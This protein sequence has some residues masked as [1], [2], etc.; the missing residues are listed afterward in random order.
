MATVARITGAVGRAFPSEGLSL[1]HS[2]GP[3]AFQEV[4]HL[5]FHIHPR[6]H[7]STVNRPL[8]RCQ[9]VMRL[10]RKCCGAHELRC[11]ICS[12]SRP[13]VIRE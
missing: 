4:P 6:F 10:F 12:T 7:D 13:T 5:H 2:I 1:W 3:A 9:P 8:S 11:N